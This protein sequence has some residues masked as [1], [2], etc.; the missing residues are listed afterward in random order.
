MT[1]SG[2]TVTAKFDRVSI[3]TV[4]VASARRSI[5]LM[6]TIVVAGPVLGTLIAAG[7][8]AAYGVSTLS[9]VM[10][11]I[12]YTMTTLGVTLGF[13]RYFAHRSFRTS[14]PMEIAFVVIGS[15]AL[16]GSL[17]YWVST[18]RRHH[19][20][21]DTPGDPHSP[22]MDG[23][24][25]LGWLSGLWHSHVGWMFATDIT[26]AMRFAP[27]IIRDPLIFRVQLR[28]LTWAGLGLALPG[29]AGL[30]ITGSWFGG[31]EAF[32]LAGPVRLLLV[33]HASWAVGS[34]SH[35]YGRRP[36]KTDDHSANNFWV[37]LLA[38]G[39]GLQN[40][41]HAFPTAARHAFLWWEP[42][43]TGYIVGV[44]SF[45]GLIWEVSKPP[46]ETIARRRLSQA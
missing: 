24:S 30:A 26:N 10:F 38:F 44:M 37:A 17:L 22:Y 11:A 5:R 3:T 20:F 25:R 7:L 2:K 43:L 23:E 15:M 35:M 32:L 27:D 8:A 14:R 28:Y 29:L 31:L 45:S 39:E 9:L 16:Q 13:H 42:D 41:H 36:F 19:Q 33:H 4:P 34:I 46:A 40:N 6:A 1:T 21:S 12:T 18:H